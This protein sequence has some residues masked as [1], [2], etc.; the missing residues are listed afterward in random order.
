M[1][2][3]GPFPSL[4][5]E[6]RWVVSLA[7]LR[8]HELSTW[9]WSLPS[10]KPCLPSHI[11]RPGGKGLRG[12]L[13]IP[14]LRKRGNAL[15]SQEYSQTIR[16]RL[17]FGSAC[18]ETVATLFGGKVKMSFPSLSDHPSPRLLR[19]LPSWSSNWTKR[20]SKPMEEAVL[21][22]R[23]AVQKPWRAFG[24]FV[25]TRKETVSIGGLPGSVSH[26]IRNN[27]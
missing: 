21:L 15:A 5:A 27:P 6:G 23:N 9:P 11:R 8:I 14:P 17:W 25:A 20:G 24:P 2:Y 7:G 13:R 3:Y 1:A 16:I 12:N 22:V 10:A 26:L 19:T 4:K 18:G